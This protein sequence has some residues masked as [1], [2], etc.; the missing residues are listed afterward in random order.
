MASSAVSRLRRFIATDRLN[1][2]RIIILNVANPRAHRPG[3]HF[4]RRIGRKHCFKLRWLRRFLPSHT[5]HTSGFK[6]AGIRL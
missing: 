2:A 5:G 1:Q 3:S 6:T 4:R